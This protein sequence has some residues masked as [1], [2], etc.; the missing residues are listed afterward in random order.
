MHGSCQATLNHHTLPKPLWPMPESALAHA[1]PG[2]RSQGKMGYQ[3]RQP[4]N[5]IEETQLR[6]QAPKKLQ[7]LL[8]KCWQLAP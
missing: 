4:D 3:A 7:A 2:R 8:V 5:V 6:L 1:S